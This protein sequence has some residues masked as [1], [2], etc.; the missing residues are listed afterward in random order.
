MILLRTIRI[1]DLTLG[2][3]FSLMVRAAVV[4]GTKRW[5]KP[6]RMP[7]SRTAAWI[8]RVRSRNSLRL[9]VCS[10]RV[11]IML[12]PDKPVVAGQGQQSAGCGGLTGFAEVL[13]GRH[14][15]H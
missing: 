15:G 10:V 12:P 5:Q 3:A 2:S 1:S 6:S 14:E 13:Q 7:L 4:W 11:C 9:L 8:S